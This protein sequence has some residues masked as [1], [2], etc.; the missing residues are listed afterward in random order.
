MV[1]WDSMPLGQQENRLII[2]SK[3]NPT[4]KILRKKDKGLDSLR[5]STRQ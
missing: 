4:K 5:A 2:I 1:R 3:K